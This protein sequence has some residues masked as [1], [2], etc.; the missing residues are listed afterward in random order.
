MAIGMRADIRYGGEYV[1]SYRERI[2]DVGV[3]CRRMLAA[4]R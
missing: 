1:A 3:R 4:E 2:Y